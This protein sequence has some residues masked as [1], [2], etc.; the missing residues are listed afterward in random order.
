MKKNFLLFLLVMC[1]MQSA[2]SENPPV[3]GIL[4][5]PGITNLDSENTIDQ[6]NGRF[7]FG[8]GIKYA[9]PLSSTL[10]L[11]TRLSYNHVQ[12]NLVVPDVGFEGAFSTEPGDEMAGYANYESFLEND[13]M[14]YD[15][16]YSFLTIPVT[17]SQF[18]ISSENF[19]ISLRGGVAFSTLLNNNTK[20][21]TGILDPFR[22]DYK[23]IN[24]SWIMGCPVRFTLQE[25]IK[26]HVEPEFSYMLNDFHNSDNLDY[27]LYTVGVNVGFT[28]HLTKPEEESGQE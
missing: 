25:N 9:F 14:E 20:T 21:I 11:D 2:N 12:T 26:L 19:N 24:F 18:L 6:T 27:R 13:I 4:F 3:F 8:G 22:D 23:N 1:F 10:S 5:Q 17:V 7:G 28:F 15:L 16:S